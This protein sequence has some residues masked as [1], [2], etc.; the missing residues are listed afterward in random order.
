M[1][2]HE[3]DKVFAGSVPKFYDEFMVPLIFAPY[4]TETAR[5]VAALE[6]KKILEIAAGTGV[7][8]RAMHAVLPATSQIVATDLNEAMLQH[9][10]STLTGDRV[11]WRQADAL[12]LPF[13]DESFD[14]VVCQFGAMFFPDR[15]RAYSEARRVLKNNGA[16][17]FSVWDR[18][19][20]N[21]FADTITSSLE[22][23]FPQDPPRFLARTPH[24]YFDRATIE[25][26]LKRGGF[27]TVAAFDTVAARSPADSPRIPAIAYCEGTPLRDEI[28]ARNPSGLSQATDTATQAIADTYGSGAVDAKI[29][30]H[31]ILTFKTQ[32][33]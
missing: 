17:L 29:Q 1:I 11:A 28:T 5:R 33:S 18:I 13:P 3:G 26:D 23:L 30:A 20:D 7:L 4:A 14:V 32:E 9:A 25:E 21:G 22:T 31:V 6:P 15:P 8:T 27:E 12:D 19:E 24:G 16:F 2:A 10:A